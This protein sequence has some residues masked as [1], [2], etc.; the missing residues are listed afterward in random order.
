MGRGVQAAFVIHVDFDGEICCGEWERCDREELGGEPD[1]AGAG[2]TNSATRLYG[3]EL[4]F[5][6]IVCPAVDGEVL[7][8]GEL[9]ALGRTLRSAKGLVEQIE[10][11]ELEHRIGRCIDCNLLVIL[12]RASEDSEFI[13]PERRKNRQDLDT[14]LKKESIRVFQ[15]KGSDRPLVTSRRRMCV[16]IRATHKHFLPGGVV[17]DASSSGA[18]YFME[19]KD[20]VELNNMEVKLLNYEKEEEIA[21]LRSFSEE[22][23]KAEVEIRYLIDRV[24]EVDLACARA[25]YG[26]WMHGVCP[27]LNNGREESLFLDIEGIR[28]PLLL[29]SSLQSLASDKYSEQGNAV[30]VDKWPTL[31]FPV[32]IDLKIGGGITV[33]VISG[34]NTGGKTASMKTLDLASLLSKAGMYLSAG[35]QPKIPWF[36]LVLADIGDHEQSFST[37]SGHISRIC[38]ILEVSLKNSLVLI[39]EIGSGTDPSEGVALSTSI[40]QYLKDRVGLAVITTHYADLSKLKDNDMRFENAAMESSLNTLLPTYR[41]LWGTRLDPNKQQER[42]GLLY[43]SLMEECQKLETQAKTAASIYSE[44][45]DLYREIRDEAS[46]LDNRVLALRSQKTQQVRRELRTAKTQIEKV[47]QDFEYQVMNA[48]ADQYN[49]LMRK[50]ESTIM[51]IV[52]ANEPSDGY[53]TKSSDNTAYIPKIGDQV[54]VKGLGDKVAT[55][56]ESPG[57]DETVLV[58][59]QYG[60]LRIRV[61]TANLRVISNRELNASSASATMKKKGQQTRDSP[62][63]SETRTEEIPFGPAI[64]TS[65]NTVDLRGMRVEEASQYLDMAISSTDSRSVLFI[66]HGMGTGALKEGVY[67]MLKSNPRIAKFEQENPMN[68]GCTVAYIK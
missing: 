17:L 29:E 15:A 16:G 28:H 60:K 13:R 62:S 63:I 24:L 65:K 43:L 14:L 49:T 7:S 10:A 47:L 44:I 56:V 68:Y 50:S 66:I 41:I 32:P 53:V 9:C 11:T 1:A 30:N 33:V 59:V 23:A 3:K 12:D 5:S 6:G 45:I 20:A 25:G 54:Y 51:A 39:D 8:V 67:D 52:K 31:D 40:L 36:D 55:I 34:P 57:D 46:D 48:S 19:P 58:V 38:K 42:K 2:E 64:Q 61:K 4:D 22:I 21:I 26:R 18:T 27:T 35:N 37:F